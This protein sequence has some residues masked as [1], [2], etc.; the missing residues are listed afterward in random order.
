MSEYK[1]S[2]K[3]LHQ[4]IRNLRIEVL[5]INLS[6]NSTFFHKF[7]PGNILYSRADKKIIVRDK[8]TFEVNRSDYVQWYIFTFLNEKSWVKA[9]ECCYNETEDIAILDIGS[10]VGEFS[11]KV[12]TNTN[13]N[14]KIYAFDPNPIIQNLFFKNLGLNKNIKNRVEFI[15]KAVGM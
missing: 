13:D 12:A 2:V 9:V 8:T 10:N 5:F 4:I 3:I 6:K 7:I 1:K 15:N 14:V 11:L